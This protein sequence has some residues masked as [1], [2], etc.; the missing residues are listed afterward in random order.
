MTDPHTQDTVVEG[1][2]DAFAG[3]VVSAERD[4][5]NVRLERIIPNGVDAGEPYVFEFHVEARPLDGDAAA[6]VPR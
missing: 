3:R 5:E 4:A 1:I 6:E 2:W